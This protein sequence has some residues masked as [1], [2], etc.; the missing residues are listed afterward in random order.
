MRPPRSVR[1]DERRW[2]TGRSDCPVVSLSAQRAPA[3]RQGAQ[4]GAVEA[5]G[6]SSAVEFDPAVFP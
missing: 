3:G 6:P 2:R 4:A 5:P 1:R